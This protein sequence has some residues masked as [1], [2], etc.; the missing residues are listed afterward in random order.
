VVGEDNRIY[1]THWDSGF[2]WAEDWFV[3]SD[4]NAWPG[5]QIAASARFPQRLDIFVVGGDSK[6][7]TSGWDGANGWSRW[8][9]VGV[10]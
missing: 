6:V 1:S 4:G 3:I 5:S 10:T 2:P 9:A 8:F 7:Y